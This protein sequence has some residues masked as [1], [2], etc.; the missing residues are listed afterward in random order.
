MRDQP[1]RLSAIEI[2]RHPRREQRLVAEQILPRD[3]AQV[4]RGPGLEPGPRDLPRDRAQVERLERLV[5]LHARRA[6]RL[7]LGE[8]LRRERPRLG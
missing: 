8:L 2:I 6:D 1:R 5:K 7:E 4:E 3:R